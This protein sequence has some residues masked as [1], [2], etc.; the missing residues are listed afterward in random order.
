MH[1]HEAIVILIN[2]NHLSYKMFELMD[3]DNDGLFSV[4]DLEYLEE[5]QVST[6]TEE[7]LLQQVL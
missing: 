2:L 7:Y 1:V 6:V 5:N 4:D 3:G